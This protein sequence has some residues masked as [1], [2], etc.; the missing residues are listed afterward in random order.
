M[1]LIESLG[2]YNHISVRRNASAL[3]AEIEGVQIS[4]VLKD[5][6]IFDEIIQAFQNHQ[7]TLFRDQKLTPENH[8][9]FGERFGELEEHPFV[10]P[11]AGYPKIMR[12]VREPEDDLNFGNLWHTDM[13]FREHPAM[14]TI[15]YARQTPALGGDTMFAN[16]Y[17]A[18]DTLSDGLKSLLDGLSAVHSA[19]RQFG[20]SGRSAG[21]QGGYKAWIF[22]LPKTH[23][24]KS[25]TRLFAPTP[26]QAAKRSMSTAPLPNAL[27]A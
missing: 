16:Q 27:M 11:L 4:D 3:G 10:S 20:L 13:S 14:A 25:S 17:M 12:V 19:A 2:G 6:K 21:E 8:M 7:V 22:R 5:D 1:A 15:L 26:V 18:Y 24:R 23:T 9:A